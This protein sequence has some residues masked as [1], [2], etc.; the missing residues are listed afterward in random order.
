MALPNETVN[1]DT[2]ECSECGELLHIE[3]LQSTAGY[4]IGF[5]CPNDGP[6][7]RESAYFGT[8]EKAEEAL[9]TGNFQR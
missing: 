4:Y 6:Y 1:D 9:A 7:S 8:R 5:F 2:V 3:V